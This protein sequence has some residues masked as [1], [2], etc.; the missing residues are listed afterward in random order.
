MEHTGH[1]LITTL[2]TCA[3]NV[4]SD[5]LSVSVRLKFSCVLFCKR[6]RVNDRNIEYSINALSTSSEILISELLIYKNYLKIHNYLS[7]LV[8]SADSKN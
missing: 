7:L 2:L 3:Y 6:R 5:D 4:N 8:S 1:T